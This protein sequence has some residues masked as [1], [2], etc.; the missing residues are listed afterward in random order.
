MKNLLLSLAAIVLFTMS[1]NAQKQF[2]GIIKTK[3]SL[4]G[5]GIDVSVKAQYPITTELK[6]LDNKTR[7]DINMGGAGMTIIADGDNHKNYQIF[8]FSIAGK[9]I[10]YMELPAANQDTKNYDFQYYKEDKKTIAGFV[11][12]KVICTITDLE[13]DET[14]ELIMY[15]S[16]DFLP[17]FASTDYPG[18][19]GFSLYT[20]MKG[21]MNGSEYSLIT[22]VIEVKADKKVKPVNFLLPAAAVP[23]AQAPAEIKTMLGMG[24]EDDD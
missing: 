5:E 1:M 22:E 16:D 6:V 20:E 11:C 23:M 21:E 7:I 4:D 10:Y 2:A 14:E 17:D 18:F 19:K 24:N 8:D 12:Y 9:G 15:V 13:T 3:I